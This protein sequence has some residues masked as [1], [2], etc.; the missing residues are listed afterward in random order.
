MSK[1]A[2]PAVVGA[3]VTGAIALLTVGVIVFGSGSLFK[4]TRKWVLHFEGSIKGL[5]PGSPVV[6]NG[7]RIGEVSRIRVVID[8]DQDIRLALRAL[9]RDEEYEVV[10]N[11]QLSPLDPS[12]VKWKPLPYNPENLEKANLLRKNMTDAEKKIWYDVLR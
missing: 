2:N 9:L 8:D 4:D 11:D 6:F 10:A 1:K 5:N 3:F 7:V 12:A